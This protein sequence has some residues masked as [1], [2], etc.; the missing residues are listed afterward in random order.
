MLTNGLLFAGRRRL[1]LRELPRDRI[2]FQISLDSPTPALHDQHRGEGTWE[3]ARAGIAIAREEGFR[4]RLAATVSDAGAEQAFRAFVEREGIPEEDCVLRRVAL[5]GFAD[6][7]G[8]AV[9][10]GPGAGGDAHP[11]RRLLA[12]GGGDGP[13]LLRHR[14]VLPARSRRS[15]RSGSPSPRSGASPP[16][17]PASSGAPSSLARRTVSLAQRAAPGAASWYG[18]YFEAGRLVGRPA[19]SWARVTK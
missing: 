15:T 6:G 11:G 5:R 3:K 13:G 9:A 12:P 7:G 18:G 19:S 2:V 17:W 4:V 10:V 14:A 8:G 16:L 1:A